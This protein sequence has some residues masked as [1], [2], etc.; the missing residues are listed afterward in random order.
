MSTRDE[1]NI[2]RCMLLG[3]TFHYNDYGHPERANSRKYHQCIGDHKV[4]FGKSEAEA[5][6]DYLRR[7][8]PK[9]LEQ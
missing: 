7:Y 8:A 1:M 4:G 3:C 5:A 2:T 9:L 6:F